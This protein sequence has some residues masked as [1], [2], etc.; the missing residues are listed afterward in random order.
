[1]SEKLLFNLRTKLSG[2]TEGN[3]PANVG[4]V[5]EPAN[6]KTSPVVDNMTLMMGCGY[7]GKASSVN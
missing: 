1:M 7:A 6:S 3:V 5:E 4:R 2:L